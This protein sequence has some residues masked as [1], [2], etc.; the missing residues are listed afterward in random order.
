LQWTQAEAFLAEKR[1]EALDGV[2]AVAVTAVFFNHAVHAKLLWAGV[3]LFFILS[4]F[5]ITGILI[6]RK[7]DPIGGYFGHFYE[8]RVKRI[9]P[10][11]LLLL[12][13]T[14][15]IFGFSWLHRWYYYLFFMNYLVG[16]R[17][18]HPEPLGV[19]WS[20][21][22]E[23][24][25]YFVWPF[26]VYFLRERYI[27]LTATALIIAAPVLRYLCTPLFSTHF[28]IYALTPFR[29]DLLAAGALLTIAWRHHR[30]K[31]E[32]FGAWG[33]ALAVVAVGVLGALSRNPHFR[34]DAN[35]P[36]VNTWLYELTLI[37]T[38]GVILWAL[39]GKFVGILKWSPLRYIGR[40]SYQIYLIHLSMLYLTLRWFH[41]PMLS[42]AV[43]L[44]MT[45]VYA[46]LSWHFLEQP[47][48]RKRKKAV[49]L[50]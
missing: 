6:D 13:F 49:A 31:M 7:R 14:C 35:T 40:I 20:L 33:I 23:E 32:R 5:L 48:L 3:D 29:M 46:A 50:S 18:P 25:F 26:F 21:A 15:A 44:V 8:R 1:I 27:A 16:Y 38:T 12:L 9:L 11:Y 10:P 2:R 47:L 41:R 28:A 45:L 43:A 39:S 34:N 22:V 30:D 4:G 36:V 42:V 19:L 17:V 37:A 24:Q